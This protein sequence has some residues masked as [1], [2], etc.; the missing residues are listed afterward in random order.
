AK[1]GNFGRTQ[2]LTTPASSDYRAG[3]YDYSGSVLVPSPTSISSHVG[4]QYEQP[5]SSWQPPPRYTPPVG[6][7]AVY[8]YDYYGL[9][10]YSNVVFPVLQCPSDPST[11]KSQ[12]T[13]VYRYDRG[14]SF[15]NYQ[16]NF[17]AF[18][19][20]SG[21]IDAVGN[22][23]N[24]SDGLSHTLLY[25]EAMRFCDNTAR[26]AFWSDSVYRHSH[27]FGIDW[28]GAANTY[29]FQT[30]ARAKTCNNWRMQAMHRGGLPATFA[31]GSVQSIGR[32]LSRREITN[33]DVDGIKKG[34]DPQ[35]GDT[36]GIWDCLLLPADRQA[37]SLQF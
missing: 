5:S 1:G 19:A 36:L 21:K 35:M 32:D 33:P 23:R 2:T 27:N 31:D 6:T 10:A 13:F 30:N 28:E 18:T 26:L 25:A 29:M 24:L 3:Y 7:A 20:S 11:Y 8:A 9:D 22:F 15:T 34:V 14:S 4:H 17:H 16:A 37:I 12:Q